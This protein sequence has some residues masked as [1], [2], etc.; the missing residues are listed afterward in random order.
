MVRDRVVDIFRR[1]LAKGAAEGRWPAAEAPFSVEA[2][3]DPRHGDFAV[4]AA[5]VLAKAA[6]V[7][8][9]RST[10]PAPGS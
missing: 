3:R 5:M 1:A 2:P 8:S 6:T 10:S 4:N 7:R 9:H